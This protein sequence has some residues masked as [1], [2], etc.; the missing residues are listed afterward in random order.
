MLA[1]RCGSQWPPSVTI[2]L[3]RAR[4]TRVA[5][6]FPHR[7]IC[8]PNVILVLIMIL[9][10]M[11]WRYVFAVLHR[12]QV[13]RETAGPRPHY[14]NALQR[15]FRILERAYAGVIAENGF[16]PCSGEV[17]LSDGRGRAKTYLHRIAALTGGTQ[18]DEGYCLDVGKTRFHVRDRYVRRLRDSTSPG[19]GYDE[20]CFYCVR[21]G[22]PSA[23]EIASALLQLKNNPQ[24]FDKWA[25]QNGLAFKANGEVF[26]RAQ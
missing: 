21:K 8:M 11:G 3:Y 15:R 16:D 18:T 6:Y 2:R 7:G 9:A 12:K 20:S 13:L 17:C 10:L 26:T 19:C 14:D 24:L 1:G 5:V 4:R 23:E 25:R 22:M